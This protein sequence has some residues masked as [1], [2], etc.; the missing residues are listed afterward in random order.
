MTGAPNNEPSTDPVSGPPEAGPAGDVAAE[1][2]AGRLESPTAATAV[3]DAAAGLVE[4]MP[5]GLAAE[6]P[7]YAGDRWRPHCDAQPQVGA[8]WVPSFYGAVGSKP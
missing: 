2:L 4:A 6:P 5:A 3:L 8:G 7:V 1:L